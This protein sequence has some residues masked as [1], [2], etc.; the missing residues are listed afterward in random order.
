MISSM[1]S[2]MPAGNLP[3]IPKFKTPIEFLWATMTEPLMYGWFHI[4]CLV[5]VFVLCS[6]IIARRN[7]IGD[8]TVTR[9]LA[10]FWFIVF[11][12]EIIK[13]INFSYSPSSGEW[14]YQWYI[15]PFQFCSS[16]L[17]VL[18]VALLTKSEKIRSL[19]YSFMAS[20][21]LF[22]GTAVMLYPSTV[23]IEDVSINLQTM[24]HHGLMVVSAVLIIATKKASLSPKTVLRG[25]AVF[26]VLVSVAFALNIIF[27]SKDGFNMFYIDVEGCHLPILNLI[28]D[29]VPYPAFLL[30]YFLGFTVC[31]LAIVAI[32]W[33]ISKG[34]EAASKKL[35]HH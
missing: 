1:P 20:F 7:K 18:P 5:A 22:A 17:Y 19:T 27:A 23:F 2:Y 8:K 31:A 13:Q 30:C 24:I 34:I 15:F 33:L 28:F 4:M 16:I 26:S 32:A 12:F 29:K 25:L 9:A 11:I 6:I 3:G 21:N 35:L 14:A 10:V